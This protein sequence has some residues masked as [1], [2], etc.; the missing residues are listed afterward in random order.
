MGA[1]HTGRR[2]G[3]VAGAGSADWKSLR[4][5]VQIRRRRSHRGG[6]APEQVPDELFAVLRYAAEEEEAGLVRFGGGAD[7]IALAALS[8]AAEQVQR[9]MP[10]YADEPARWAPASGTSRR[11]GVQ[12]A[13]HPR[14]TPR[15]APHFPARDFAGGRGRDAEPVGDGTAVAGVAVLLT[16]RDDTPAAWLRAGQGLHSLLLRA[17]EDGLAAAYRTQSL[18]VPELRAVLRLRFCAGAHPQMLLRLGVPEGAEPTSV[19]RP[20]EEVLTEGP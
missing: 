14:R 7:E 11:D 3:V 15:T 6:F 19:R 20:V 18:Q 4:K 8:N 16:T 17:A 2:S 13:A 5:H 12:P 9:R 10:A 1:R